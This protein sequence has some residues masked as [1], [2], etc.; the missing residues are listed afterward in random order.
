VFGWLV[1]PAIAALL[2]V[3]VLPQLAVTVRVALSEGE[4]GT[5]TAVQRSCVSHGRSGQQCQWRGQFVADT[6][7]TREPAY[8]EGDPRGWQ[9]GTTVR[10]T[11]LP[12]QP[13]TVYRHAD[14]RP[15]LL[16]LG[17]SLVAATALLAWAVAAL[18]R[19]TGRRTPSWVGNVHAVC[20][21]PPLSPKPNR[22]G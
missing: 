9:P 6:G 11:W 8:L 4:S 18:C 15:L 22:A 14:P 7:M 17:L 20:G 12:D 2:L 5:F 13:S 16:V 1:I 3:A 10:A 21:W 19:L